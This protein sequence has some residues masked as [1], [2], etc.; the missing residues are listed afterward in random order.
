MAGSCSREELTYLTVD[1]IEDLSKAI[2]VKIPNRRRNKNRTFMIGGQYLDFYRKYVDMRPSGIVDKRFFLSYRDGKCTRQVVGE[3]RIGAIAQEIAAYLKLPNAKDYTGRSFRSVSPTFLEDAGADIYTPPCEMNS[4][5]PANMPEHDASELV[6]IK[7]EIDESSSDFSVAA[8]EI[9]APETSTNWM[10]S[11]ENDSKI[12][13]I[14]SAIGSTI[15]LKD[16]NRP[17]IVRNCNNCTFNI[18]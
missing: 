1:N 18:R 9:D 12:A 5:F 2:L 10:A 3:H 16:F 14:S 17:I 15:D 4:G 8:A 7:A 13:N 6:E 11:L